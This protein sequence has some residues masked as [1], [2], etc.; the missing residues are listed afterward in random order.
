[1]DALAR[2]LRLKLFRTSVKE[3][4]NVEQGVRGRGRKGREGMDIRGRREGKKRD[5]WE[6]G[7]GVWGRLRCECSTVSSSKDCLHLPADSLV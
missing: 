6:E 7:G 4:F 3:N 2:R 5:G 1:M